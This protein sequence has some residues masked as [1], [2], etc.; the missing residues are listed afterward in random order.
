LNFP[1]T[2]KELDTRT[3][4]NENQTSCAETGNTNGCP[5][6]ENV[7]GSSI[8]K[9]GYHDLS[10]SVPKKPKT[11]PEPVIDY[12]AKDISTY[13]MDLNDRKYFNDDSPLVVGCDCYTCSHHVRAYLH[14]LLVTKEMLAPVLLVIHNITHWFRFFEKIRECSL[15][16][17]LSDLK[18][19][20]KMRNL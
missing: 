20:V 13:E 4:E 5:S 3:A 18:E 2:Q 14:H 6:K 17:T 15:Q 16:G 1:C 19:I 11:E 7:N 9:Q 12:Y 8:S 10:E